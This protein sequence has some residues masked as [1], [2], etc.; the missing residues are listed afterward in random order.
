MDR[1]ERTFLHTLPLLSPSFSGSISLSLL[2]FLSHRCCCR[3]AP[4]AS[5]SGV[6]VCAGKVVCRRR[7]AGLYEG[8]TY[9][10]TTQ[11]T[12]IKKT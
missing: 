9:I 1:T 7:R 2:A 10:D 11:P 12:F 5:S 6:A 3:E 8:G 4:L